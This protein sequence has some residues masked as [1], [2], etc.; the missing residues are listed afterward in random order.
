VQ[1][2]SWLSNWKRRRESDVAAEL[3]ASKPEPAARFVKQLA[4]RINPRPA[5]PVRTRTRLGLA[6][7]VTATMVAVVG[8]TG[9]FSSAASTIS[10]ATHSVVHIA[11]ISSTPS[12][13]VKNAAAPRVH[14][15]G[16]TS[17]DTQYAVAPTISGFTPNSGPSGQTVTVQGTHFSG[18]SA[19]SSVSLGDS[20]AAPNV[21]SDSTLTFQVPAGAT[22]GD[23]TVANAAGPATST[24]SFTVIQIPQFSGDTPYSPADGGVGTAVTLSGT[25][26]TGVTSVTIGGKAAPIDSISNTEID[27]E[28]P[29][30]AKV[31]TGS[32]TI[33]NAA[34]SASASGFVVDSGAPT[35]TSFSPASGSAG[36]SIKITGTNLLTGDK[37]ADVMFNGAADAATLTDGKTPTKTALYVNVPDDAESG[38]IT[39][40]NDLGN[41]TSK[42]SFVVLGTP[43]ITGVNPAFGIKSTP[44]IITG[45]TFTGAKNVI[46]HSSGHPDV[47]VSS[48]L[49]IKGDTQITV[50]APSTLVQ[51]A[52]Y[53][54]EVTGKTLDVSDP[55]G[56]F[57]FEAK[58]AIDS[59]TPNQGGTGLAVAIAPPDGNT[60]L[61]VTKVTFGG[62]AATITS[63]TPTEVDVLVPAGLNS[64]TTPKSVAVVVSNA[65]GPS[66]ASTFTAVNSAPTIKTY[67][68]SAGNV[69]DTLTITGS[70]LNN[71][72]TS[73]TFL[74]GDSCTVAN[75]DLTK[76]T[77]GTGSKAVDSISFEI[78]DCAAT[79]LI[80]VDNAD[81]SAT[82]KSF[83]VYQQPVVLGIKPA[84][85][86]SKASTKVT[87]QGAPG[88]F[89]GAFEVDFDAHAVKTG[90]VVAKDGASLTVTAPKLAAATYKVT[91]SVNKLE[92]LSGDSGNTGLTIL[93]APTV[94][95]FGDTDTG[96][97]AGDTLT[98]KGTNFLGVQS[99]TFGSVKAVFQAVVS[100]GAIDPTQLTVTIP[101]G[102]ISNKISVTTAGGKGTSSATYPVLAISKVS[103]ASAKHGKANQTITVTG[104]GFKFNNV[105]VTLNVGGET[106]VPKSSSKDTSLVFTLPT[107]L[108]AGNVTIDL[109][110]DL[111]E[112][113]ATLKLT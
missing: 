46:F 75:D 34:G 89:T 81:G 98:V 11:H 53:S 110:N 84:Y 21:I 62:K 48:G 72:D 13:L 68:P 103:P 71:N 86:S 8:A 111:G 18:A 112:V 47:T 43:N 113:T 40:S 83:T 74:S 96:G 25:N 64:S 6:A 38:A 55:A 85:G 51:G 32:I 23:I 91:V 49:T 36:D 2:K 106:V 45:D 90:I 33:K 30:G 54:V 100:G 52:T 87:V 10:G 9:G 17:A 95:G 31:G 39:V 92:P 24:D 79:G 5:Q 59:L 88:T 1:L 42:T 14:T 70:F 77:T 19:V 97:M 99:V 104:T 94:T 22:S 101:N 82:G 78:P 107:D 108:A 66:L 80:E 73:V 67:A 3:R 50:K 93:D 76:R 60:F 61:G 69:G 7:A 20:P 37:A 109:T 12:A 44:V 105:L 28:V 65:A 15:S 4:A 26:F 27:T 41:S 57:Y 63:N 56:S 29:T 102:A 16:P 58:P 35:V